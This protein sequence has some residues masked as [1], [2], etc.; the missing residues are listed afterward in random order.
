MQYL[1]IGKG[2]E[3][4]PNRAT[5]SEKV[6]CGLFEYFCQETRQKK[7]VWEVEK[8]SKQDPGFCTQPMK[9]KAAQSVEL[10]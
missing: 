8:G 9:D 1:K 7:E 2:V 3:R 5:L 6:R 10:N 4:E